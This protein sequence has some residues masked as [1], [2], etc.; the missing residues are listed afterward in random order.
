MGFETLTRDERER[1]MLA[2]TV[3]QLEY[4]AIIR[5]MRADVTTREYFQ[6]PDY[7]EAKSRYAARG[8]VDSHVGPVA[9]RIVGVMPLA[10][11]KRGEVVTTLN[12]DDSIGEIDHVV[13]NE[14]NDPSIRCFF[15]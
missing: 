2:K 4:V 8:N 14:D 3:Q 11:V 5:D 6:A 1:P 10:V 15:E 12:P 13:S 9:I 7:L